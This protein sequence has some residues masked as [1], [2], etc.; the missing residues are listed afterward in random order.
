MQDKRQIHS[1]VKE[2]TVIRCRNFHSLPKDKYGWD[3]PSMC[4]LIFCTRTH[5]TLVSM[6]SQALHYNKS[7]VSPSALS[8]IVLSGPQCKVRIYQILYA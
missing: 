2:K 3:E 7:H 4:D 6:I 1:I 8:T 5:N